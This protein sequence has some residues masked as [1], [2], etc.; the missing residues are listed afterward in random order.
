MLQLTPLQPVDNHAPHFFSRV[1][2]INASKS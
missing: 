2:P 1:Y